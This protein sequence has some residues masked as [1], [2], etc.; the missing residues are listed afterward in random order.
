MANAGYSQNVNNIISTLNKKADTNLANS[1]KAGEIE[2]I[3]NSAA[4]AAQSAATVAHAASELINTALPQKINKNGDTFNGSV[5]VDGDLTVTGE[6]NATITGSSES[7]MS[8]TKDSS[9]NVIV[10]TYATKDQLNT[11]NTNVATNTTNITTA[12]NRADSAYTLA[13]SKVSSSNG[14][15][16]FILDDYSVDFR[17]AGDEDNYTVSLV[18]NKILD[19]SKVYNTLIDANGK[20]LPEFGTDLAV[21]NATVSLKNGNDVISSVTVNNVANA[22]SATKATQDASGN[23]IVDTYATK[24][25]L[26]TGLSG[27]ADSS[28]GTHV[29]YSTTAPKANGTADVGTA[30]TVSRSDHVHPLQTTVSG[31]SGSCTGNAATATKLAATKTISISG[32]ATGT[33]TAFDGSSNITIPV[34]ALDVSK[35]TAGTLPVARGGTG[36]TASPSMLTNLAST[37]AD[38]VLQASP[39][40]G[41]TG[42]LPVANGG[43][44]SSTKNFVD[45][46]SD[47]TIAGIKTFTSDI[48]QNNAKPIVVH[49]NSGLT[50]GT[51]P[52][53]A[54][55]WDIEFTD[56]YG[57]G[58]TNRIG[59]IVTTL[60]TANAASTSMYA[61]KQENGASTSATIGIHYP[62]S[63]NPYATAPTPDSTTND[64]K[65]ATTAWVRDRINK[66][67]DCSTDAATVAKEVTVDGFVLET[68][69]RVLIRF[70]VTNTAASPTL[71]VSGTGAKA[72][73]YRN[74]AITA[75]YLAAN[76]IYE[77]VYDGAQYELIGDVNTDTNT[78][79]TQ[80][81]TTTNAEY[82]LLAMADAAATANKTNSTRFASAVTLNPSTQ[83]ITAK[84]LKSP[85]LGT[86][87][88]ST[89]QTDGAVLDTSVSSGAYMGYLRYPST[90]G[91]FTFAGYKGEIGFY[92]LTKENIDAGTNTVTHSLKFNESGLLTSSGGFKGALTGNAS[93][94]T[95]ATQDSA[96]QQINTTYIKGL[97]V[98]GKT[99]TYTKGDGTTGTITTQ[100]TNTTYSNMTAATA[101][102]DGKAGLVPAPAAGKQTSFLRGDGTWVVPTNTDTK[103]TNT[104]AT[105]T[106]AYVTGTTSATTNTG[107]QV[108]DTGVYLGTTAGYLH[109]TRIVFSNGAQLWVG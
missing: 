70:T 77:F 64:T 72:I 97:S 84:G 82:A 61:Y 19:N 80:T 17:R 35:A 24:S 55:Y 14:T 98:S 73:Y 99:I 28:H 63:G 66:I 47:Q 41:V 85:A 9:G 62:A 8:A 96:G 79:V 108:F 43:T 42:V 31:S 13:N 21:N 23:V 88:V 37:T 100:D 51:A 86:S 65:I 71:N 48:K 15:M 107:T 91:A 30:T 11:T 68:G 90:N 78:K 34:T 93:T 59:A 95:K 44:G 54:A 109:V 60:T 29:T 46:S 27:K 22:T 2:S 38:N 104:L 33:A 3:A 16:S 83:R 45:L 40:P 25:E 69:A 74:A 18:T 5:V 1:A 4:S 81:V 67:V 7:A 58:S 101:D 89:A 94:A 12:Q 92:Y 106:K 103:V 6:I 36:L 49:S 10:D 57:S 50:K 20:F 56:K 53:T 26:T 75:G 102:A 32:G 39:R 52:N 105:T 87:Y 76:R